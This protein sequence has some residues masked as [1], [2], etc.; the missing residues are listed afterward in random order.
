M[1]EE[2]EMTA[3]APTLI[4][5]IEDALGYCR[6][7]RYCG[8]YLIEENVGGIIGADECICNNICCLIRHIKKEG[9]LKK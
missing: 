5:I 8:V 4:T 7:C 1:S 2:L 3:D 6:I 9:G